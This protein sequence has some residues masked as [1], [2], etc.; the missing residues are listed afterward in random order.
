[1][2]D[3]RNLTEAEMQDLAKE[4]GQ[5]AFRGRQLFGWVYKGRTDFRE[6]TNLPEVFTAWL[7]ENAELDSLKL[8]AHQQS[9]TD[10]TQKF[11]YGLKDGNAV[12]TVFMKYKYGNTVC[13]SSQAGCR[14]HCAFCASGINGLVRS[15]TAGEIISQLLDTER[16]TGEKISR[17][18]VM[19]TGE[20]FD[21]YEQI[22]RFIRIL[23]EKDGRNM[24]SRNI[25][26]STCGLV[27]GIQKFSEDFPQV[28]LAVS[29]HAPVSSLRDEL[30]PV[31]HSYPLEELIPACRA[32]TE[33]T[34][35]RITFE[36]A[37]IRGKNDT[38]EMIGKLIHLLR[39]MLCHVNLIPLNEVSETGLLTSGRKR[40]EEIQKRLEES[41]IPATVRRQLGADIDGACGQLRLKA[42]KQS[43]ESRVTVK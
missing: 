14:M 28:N 35:R 30:M 12:E 21:N 2:R 25:T 33:K 37:L 1:M 36:Y 15:L 3:L 38:D 42:Q 22:S 34:G 18:V 4:A 10:G 20:P 7:E 13:V 24:S 39:G 31:N 40:A 29:L 17:I 23:H 26:V 32:Y 16:E 9:K 6:M 8:L 11:L 43:D 5:P 41:G 27:P 19:G